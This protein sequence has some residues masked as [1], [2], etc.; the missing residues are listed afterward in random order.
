MVIG[1]GDQFIDLFYV[2]S[3]LLLMLQFYGQRRVHLSVYEGCFDE[4][5]IYFFL[6][7]S[8]VGTLV[9]FLNGNLDLK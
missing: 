3:F 1:D 5:Q 4:F 7:E 9:K 8:D 2:A 6:W